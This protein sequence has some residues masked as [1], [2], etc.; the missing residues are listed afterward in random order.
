[1]VAWWLRGVGVLAL[2]LMAGWWQAVRPHSLAWAL[3]G[4]FLALLSGRLWLGLQFAAMRAVQRRAGLPDP[5]P[6]ALWRAWQ[7]ESH[8]A[9]YFFGWAMPWREHAVADALPSQPGEAGPRP[10]VLVHGWMCNRAIWGPWLRQLQAAGIPCV[11][12]S[13]PVLFGSIEA[14]RPVLEAAVRRV[15]AAT[16]RDP[17]LVGHSMGGLVVRDWLRSLPA[18]EAP[19]VA[20][21]LSLGSPHHGTWLARWGLG[22][23]VVQMRPHSAWLQQ[24]AAD[25]ATRPRPPWTSWQADLDNVVFPAPTAQL[26]GSEV[27]CLPGWAHVQMLQAPEV[28]AQVQALALAPGHAPDR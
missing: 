8:C 21:V 23:C 9:A 17:V 20:H 19:P 6:G 15:R 25:E 27:R 11:A 24:L 18:G 12:V 7:A 2:V 1:M 5:A 28:L 3:A 10:V 16:G 4:V 22:T 26:P 13:L 14:G